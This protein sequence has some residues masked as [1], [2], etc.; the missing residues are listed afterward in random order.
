MGILTAIL[1]FIHII[2]AIVLVVAILLQASKGG[3]LAGTFGGQASSALF[4]PRGTASVLSRVT[5]YLAGS[6]LVLSIVLSFMAGAGQVTESVTQKVLKETSAAHLP[7]IEDLDFT[8]PV[9]EGTADV[10][11]SPIDDDAE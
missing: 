10:E 7:A 6:F 1:T 3:G 11:S 8:T 5:Q 9:T 2:V 4:G